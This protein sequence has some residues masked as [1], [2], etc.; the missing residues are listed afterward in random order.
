MFSGKDISNYIT[1]SQKTREVY[2][3]CLLASTKLTTIGNVAT[4]EQKY[5]QDVI[6]KQRQP[7][8]LTFHIN[9]MK[10]VDSC[11]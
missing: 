10:E 4:E 1:Y 5:Y 7:N 3:P 11:I 9:E 8:S 2:I 6:M